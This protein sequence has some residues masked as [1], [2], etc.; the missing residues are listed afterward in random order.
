LTAIFGAFFRLGVT[1][2]GGNTAAWLYRDVV[3]RRRWIDDA[4]FLSGMALGRIL[5]GSSG[6][7]LTV[8]VGQRLSG[9]A[10]AV[11][12]VAGLLSGPLLVVLALAAGWR[13]I[14]NIAALQAALDGM[15]AAAV[16]LTFATGLK[17]MR[18]AA[19]D[20]APLAIAVVTVIAVGILGWPMVTD[21]GLF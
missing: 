13:R 16:G 21:G 19:R 6:V 7:S 20:A 2:F 18:R 4:T 10:G 5:P 8:Q 15:G 17:L 1:S 12:A 14:E 11:M 9:A 3:E